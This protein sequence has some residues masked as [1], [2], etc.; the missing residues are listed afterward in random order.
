MVRR[1]N[2][3]ILK[4]FAGHCRDN[5]RAQDCNIAILSGVLRKQPHNDDLVTNA[6]IVAG[7]ML[8]RHKQPFAYREEV[9]IISRIQTKDGDI[10]RVVVWKHPRVWELEI[11]GTAACEIE[12]SQECGVLLGCGDVV[13]CGHQVPPA[14]I[15]VLSLDADIERSPT[16]PD[17]VVLPADT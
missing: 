14:V 2:S 12:S 7:K 16:E 3:S 1:P 10:G 17:C 13:A 4:R 8:R 15:G 5:S 6:D 11:F 9:D